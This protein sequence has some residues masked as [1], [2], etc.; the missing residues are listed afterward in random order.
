MP[1]PTDKEIAQAWSRATPLKGYDPDQ[2]RMAPDL[3]QAIIRRDRFNVRG[4][5]GWRIECGV[6]VSYHR[7]TMTSAMRRVE[8]DLRI[9]QP[10]QAAT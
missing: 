6:P 3:V 4:K 5:Y 9:R 2:Y 10:K 7:L 1:D 8:R